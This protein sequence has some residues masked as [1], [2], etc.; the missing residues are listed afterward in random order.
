[1]VERIEE[2]G[3]KEM[4]TSVYRKATN[5]GQYLNFKSVNSVS[6]KIATVGT[7]DHRAESYCTCDAALQ[8][9]KE[10]IITNGYPLRWLK[11]IFSEHRT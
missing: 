3:F 7:L 9:R 5:S 8:S 4:L 6:H 2:T 10:N 11:R 1:M